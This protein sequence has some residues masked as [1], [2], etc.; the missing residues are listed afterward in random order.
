M[1]VISTRALWDL[2]QGACIGG[3]W[4]EGSL[5]CYGHFDYTINKVIF[6]GRATSED[7]VV[8]FVEGFVSL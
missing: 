5:L 7:G 6:K 1:Y 8:H 2:S 3:K 4:R